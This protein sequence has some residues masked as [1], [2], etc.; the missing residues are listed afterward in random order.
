MSHYLGNLL[1]CDS[2]SHVLLFLL[3]FFLFLLEL[4]FEAAL[5]ISICSSLLIVLCED[6]IVLASFH[7]LDFLLN[8]LKL[9]RY[10]SIEEVHA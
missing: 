3:P 9:I 7:F 5:L 1:C 10:H 8:A 6:G 4:V 2:R